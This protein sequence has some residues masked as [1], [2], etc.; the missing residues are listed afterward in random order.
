VV[1]AADF[2]DWI[3]L[4]A[5]VESDAEHP[6]VRLFVV[7]RADV[8]VGNTWD[9]TG[10]RGTASNRVT[11]EQVF[12]PAELVGQLGLPP[13]ID[14]PLYRVPAFSV[15]APGGAAAVLGMARAAID[16]VVRIATPLPAAHTASVRSALGRTDAKLRAARLL[17]LDAAAHLDRTAADNAPITDRQRA[18]LRAAMSHANEVA[19]EVFVTAHE[20]AES[21]VLYRSNP[22]EQ[23]V[24][25]GLTAVQHVN[26][27]SVHFEIAGRLMLGITPD[28]SV[29]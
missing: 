7:P 14:R 16:E 24:R 5:V 29:Y 17:L 8:I 25:D 10:M 2:A 4:F 18:E 20:L 26:N 1:T 19:R 22:I 15:V 27:A 28:V 12:V 3:T 6:D 13:V 11:A 9:V 23:I 21:K